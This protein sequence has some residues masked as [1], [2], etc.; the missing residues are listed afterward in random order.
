MVKSVLS[1]NRTDFEQYVSEWE[2]EY[3]GAQGEESLDEVD[4]IA[5]NAGA[6]SFEQV[7]FDELSKANVRVQYGKKNKDYIYH[8]FFKKHPE[9]NTMEV[10][11]GIYESVS[12]VLPKDPRKIVSPP[13]YITEFEQP[14]FVECYTLIVKEVGD[15]VGAR[16][17][18]EDLF[19]KDIL[20]RL[21]ALV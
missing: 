14:F 1:M 13:K 19:V 2:N 21:N 3:V 16:R 8:I 20:N 10:M 9:K 17:I 4:E 7:L 5:S 18:M 6:P 12:R 11:Q 15:R